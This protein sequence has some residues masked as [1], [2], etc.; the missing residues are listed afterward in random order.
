M[1]EDHIEIDTGEGPMSTFVTCPEGEGPYPLVMFLMDA[2]GKREELH[3]MARRISATGYYVLLGQLYYRDVHGFT[4]HREDP[5][6]AKQMYEYMGNLTNEMSARD[7]N[8]MIDH[9]AGDPRADATKVGVTGYCMSGP[10]ALWIAAEHNDVVKCAAS[11]HGVK[12]AV[13]ADDSP[14][15]R[16]FDITGEVLV[17]AAE[18]DKW[19]DRAQY[20]R[21]DKAFADAGTTATMEWVEDCHHGYVFPQRPA[22][23]KRAAERHWELLHGLFERTLR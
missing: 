17:L 18:H 4:V 6:S 22:F 8:A 14:H 20:D 23:D 1:F 10:F 16:A 9:A 11:T 12:L 3:D 5:A 19:V 2:P 13:E 7:A 15:S 21:L